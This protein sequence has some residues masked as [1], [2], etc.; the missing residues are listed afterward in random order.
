MLRYKFVINPIPLKKRHKRI[1][2]HLEKQMFK[3][4][5]DFSYETTTK[6]KNAT[7]ISKKAKLCCPGKA[8][9]SV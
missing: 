5:I 3:E 1:L 6:E 4:G 8:N 2:R 7:E 9:S